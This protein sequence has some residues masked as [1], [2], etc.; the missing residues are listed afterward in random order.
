MYLYSEEAR[1]ELAVGNINLCAD[2]QKNKE[3]KQPLTT[4]SRLVGEVTA[5]SCTGSVSAEL[6]PHSNMY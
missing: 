2:E 5:E 3:R 6:F 4:H 1:D